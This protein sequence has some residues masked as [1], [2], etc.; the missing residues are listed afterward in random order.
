[1]FQSESRPSRC[2]HTEWVSDVQIASFQFVHFEA[3]YVNKNEC[4]TTLLF[5]HHFPKYADYV[6]QILWTLDHVSEN[7]SSTNLTRFFLRHTIVV[8]VK[9]T[10]CSICTC[11]AIQPAARWT[12]ESATYN[13]MLCFNKVRALLD[14]IDAASDQQQLT[15]R[16][17]QKQ[18]YNIIF[19]WQIQNHN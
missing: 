5:G 14:R 7:Y 16:K 10:F 4:T 13:V 11:Y 3:N 9:V 12:I 18:I 15:I 17:S 19:I 2:L 8:Q 1:M 6:C